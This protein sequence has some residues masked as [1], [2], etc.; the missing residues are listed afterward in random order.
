MPLEDLR[1]TTQVECELEMSSTNIFMD[2]RFAILLLLLHVS[3]DLFAKL[4]SRSERI[5]RIENTFDKSEEL[6]NN[7]FSHLNSL[8][9]PCWSVIL[10]VSH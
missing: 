5:E 2:K 3:F 9:E 10:S 1:F 8:F 7:V 6:V 4:V